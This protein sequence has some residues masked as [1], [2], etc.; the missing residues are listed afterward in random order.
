MLSQKSLPFILFVLMQACS[1]VDARRLRVAVQPALVSS[2][3]NNEF[4]AHTDPTPTTSDNGDPTN[5]IP[6]SNNPPT[7]S[8]HQHQL[9]YYNGLYSTNTFNGNILYYALKAVETHKN[10]TVPVPVTA[11]DNETIANITDQSRFIPAGM[12]L[13]SKVVCAK[14]LQE[15]DRET[16]LFSNTALCAWDYVCD[17]EADRYPHYLFKARCKTSKCNVTC[18][19]DKHHICQSH[20]IH[21]TV[22]EKRQCKEWVWGQ[23]L[24]PLACTCTSEAIM[25][26]EDGMTG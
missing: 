14:I 5:T 10:M 26:A 6:P 9:K 1:L 25:K 22:L 8:P 24:L 18:S 12:E 16:S 17:Y 2:L 21:V 7:C 15:I 20:G 23:D 13:V 3:H 11:E 4:H 19:Q